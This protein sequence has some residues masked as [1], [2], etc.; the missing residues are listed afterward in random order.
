MAGMTGGS[1]A[2]RGRLIA[3][4]GGEGCGKSTQAQLL[5]TSL[6]AVLTREPGGTPAG[7]RIRE[8]LLGNEVG[9]IGA[10]AELLLMAAARAE[11][12]RQ[13]ILPALAAG[14]WVVTDRFAGSTL[15]YQ[16]YGR[17]VPLEAVRAIS[18]F[19]AAGIVADLNILLELP[20]EVALSRRCGR[21][22]R[23]EAADGGFHERV[24]AGFC[25]IA[26]SDTAHWSVVEAEGTP[27]EV[28]GRVL[29][30]V[31]ARLGDHRVA[32]A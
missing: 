4:E 19:A 2:V 15:A 6:D 30:I 32:R 7:E 10:P 9:E 1:S 29:E 22:D 13:L 11:H 27:D 20:E 25:K 3:F 16:G 23:I 21:P 17:A 14:R 18:G 31:R 5:A 28:G 12:V 26:A 8:M 24:V